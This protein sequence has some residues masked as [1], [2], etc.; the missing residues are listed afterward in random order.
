MASRKENRLS[1]QEKQVRNSNAVIFSLFIF[2]IM[3]H[4]FDVWLRL[5]AGAFGF[6]H[7][8]MAFYVA[9]GA[10]AGFTIFNRGG[11]TVLP[12][13]GKG[14]AITAVAYFVPLIVRGLGTWGSTLGF[15]GRIFADGVSAGILIFA[16]VWILYFF[17][18]EGSV[19]TQRVGLAYLFLWTFIIVVSFWPAIRLASETTPVIL[20]GIQP[21]YTVAK[22]A[23]DTWT[24]TKEAYQSIKKTLGGFGTEFQQQLELAAYGDVYTGK[25]EEGAEKRLGVFMDSLKSTQTS[26]LVGQP[27]TVFSRLQAETIEKPININFACTCCSGTGTPTHTCDE[28][29]QDDCIIKPKPTLN[30]ESFDARDIDCQ[31]PAGFDTPGGKTIKLV[32][33]FDFQTLSFLRTYLMDS[34]RVRAFRRDN[35]NPLTQ[36]GITDQNPVAEFTAGPINVG[37]GVSESPLPM[38]IDRTDQEKSVTLSMTIRNAW[39]G[40]LKKISKLDLIIPDGFEL[41]SVNAY[42]MRSLNPCVPDQFS[43]DTI[44]T[45]PINQVINIPKDGVTSV[46]QL[47]ADLTVPKSE[48]G[49]VL[50]NE[51]LSVQFF[52]ANIDYEYEIERSMIVNV[53]SK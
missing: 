18:V 39:P 23:V 11:A 8:M 43:D 16:P 53:V 41:E 49:T 42:N 32:S 26:F 52:K 48:Y 46:V 12:G 45:I 51:P 31:F 17:Y 20:P 36:Y 13:L 35:I 15:T 27:V 38:Q 14:L 4:V 40:K 6:F 34:D 29:T 5:S 21:G 47:R 30:V 9:Y 25:V 22:L 37:M 24:G 1:P 2:A 28:T 33:N 50:G 10:I 3:L 7:P 44:C 19:L